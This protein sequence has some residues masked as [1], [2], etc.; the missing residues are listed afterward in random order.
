MLS[1]F[2][3]YFLLSKAW[4]C[5][6]YIPPILKSQVENSS[7]S[8]EVHC[9]ICHSMI[10]HLLNKASVALLGPFQYQPQ[11]L[12]CWHFFQQLGKCSVSEMLYSLRKH[13]FLLCSLSWE[14]FG[15]HTLHP[16]EHVDVY[17]ESKKSTC[18]VVKL[19]FLHQTKISR[20]LSKGTDCS[21]YRILEIACAWYIF[22]FPF[23]HASF[24]EK[25]GFYMSN[26]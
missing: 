12:W 16:Y 20:F 6:L 17:V 11:S 8:L 18:L 13:H 15:L 5:I 24:K 3:H 25:E 2:L 22:N 1:K 14:E 23:I 21:G 7:L 4:C 19:F 26:L 9:S 10:F